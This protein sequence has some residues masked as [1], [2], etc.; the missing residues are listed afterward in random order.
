MGA[1]TVWANSV[2]RDVTEI[3]SGRIGWGALDRGAV[4]VGPPGT[5]KTSLVRALAADAGMTLVAT[6]YAAWQAAGEG[7]LGDVI[8]TMRATFD[9]ARAAAPAILFSDELDT[10]GSRRSASTIGRGGKRDDWWR[11]VINSLLEAMDGALGMEGVLVIGA[12]ND[13][14]GLD[15]AMLRAGR[16]ERHIRVALPDADSL[17]A[18]FRVH[19]GADL[20]GTD[21]S[22]LVL[23]GLGKA[24]ADV[25]RWVRAARRRA[26]HA[27]RKMVLDDLWQE[28]LPQPSS[29]R[30]GDFDRIV[31]VHE[32]GHC[33]A[34]AL[35]RPGT[36]TCASMAA[37]GESEAA[38]SALQPG[39]EAMTE[40]WLADQLAMR[41]AGRAAEL[42]VLGMVS[43]GS[44]GS[45]TSDLAYA[46]W[47]ATAAEE[48]LGFGRSLIWRGVPGPETMATTFA[49]RPELEHRVAARLDAAYE[50]ARLLIRD[51][52]SAVEAVATALLQRRVLTGVEIEALVR[53]EALP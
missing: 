50:V 2:L 36:V 32:A 9:Q 40:A 45:P 14:S 47:L 15:P 30:D 16:L 31:A 20:L 26:R 19:L 43:G 27:D 52:L 10:L 41:L 3:R 48:A 24:G 44:G 34:T 39:S 28:V 29:C 6:S 7:Y 18:I 23:A 38:T 1:A 22:S 4:L 51:N 17:T 35:L 25:E 46:T 12:T 42:E 37:L 8:R 33:V 49:M 5:G 21:L 13:M 11:A 53:G